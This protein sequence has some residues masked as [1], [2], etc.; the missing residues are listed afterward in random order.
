[1]A[2]VEGV[3]GGVPLPEL[4][5]VSVPVGVAPAVRDGVPET[6]ARLAVVVADMVAVCVGLAVI[7]EVPVPIGLPVE[8]GEAVRVE[9]VVPRAVVVPVWVGVV[10]VVTEEL[11]VTGA[12]GSPVEETVPWAVQ[13]LLGVTL[14]VAVC[15]GVFVLVLLD[16]FV[17]V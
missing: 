17:P 14:A 15:E 8:D 13:E 6:V 11:A 7:E 9:V 12:V 5:R 1:V 4:V 10:P 2:V 3:I 16:V